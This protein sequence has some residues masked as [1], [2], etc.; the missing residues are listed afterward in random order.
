MPSNGKLPA[1]FGLRNKAKIAAVVER[2]GKS[3]PAEVMMR[4]AALMQP[5]LTL[6]QALAI[7]CAM[8]GAVLIRT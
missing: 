6:L 5:L 4:L 7:R 8:L 3:G 1:A 2:E